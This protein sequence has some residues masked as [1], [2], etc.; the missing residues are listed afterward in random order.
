MA[1]SDAQKQT[2]YAYASKSEGNHTAFE[3]F[4]HLVPDELKDDPS[5]VEAFMDGAHVVTT[6]GAVVEVSDKDLSRVESGHNGGEYTT[7]NTIMENASMNRARGADNMT[8][9]ELSDIEVV[10]DFESAAIDGAEIFGS[11]TEA[12]AFAEA[13]TS[14]SEIFEAV[15][16]GILPI[17]YGAKAAHAFWESTEGMEEG[18]RLATTALVGGSTVLATYGALALVPGLN[19]VLG[20]VAVAKVGH[21]VIEQ[22][23]KST[24]NASAQ[25]KIQWRKNLDAAARMREIEAEYE[26]KK[27]HGLLIDQQA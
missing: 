12:E 2:F 19:I 25:T 27:A 20:A 8:D 4:M 1:L 14:S 10:N 15:A 17:T 3:W 24:G 7:D 6:E 22:A 21:M 5:E 11:A 16:D 13:A 23:S 18:E 26:Y 9:A